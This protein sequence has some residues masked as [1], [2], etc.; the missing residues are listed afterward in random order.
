MRVNTALI[1]TGYLQ[2]FGLLQRLLWVSFEQKLAILPALGLIIQKR[3]NLTFDLTL[4]RNLMSI[5]KFQVIFGENSWRAF[6]PRFAGFER[7]WFSKW[8][9]GGADLPPS[10]ADVSTD[11]AQAVP[12]YQNHCRHRFTQCWEFSIYLRPRYTDAFF[13]RRF[14][15]RHDEF[16]RNFENMVFLMTFPLS[17]HSFST[18][19]SL[20][21]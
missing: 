17:V 14:P 15:S 6:E 19:K 13:T 16:R 11:I 3:Q 8:Q 9:G 12:G 2:Y 20:F 21:I 1:L 10:Q 4:T 5:L 18:K 7:H